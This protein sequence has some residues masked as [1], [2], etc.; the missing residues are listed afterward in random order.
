MFPYFQ[1][2]LISLYTNTVLNLN[3]IAGPVLY[4][5]RLKLCSDKVQRI[6]RYM[7]SDL[8]VGKIS[9]QVVLLLRVGGAMKNEASPRAS[10]AFRLSSEY[11][12]PPLEMRSCCH[13]FYLGLIS[14]LNARSVSMSW[15]KLYQL[16]FG[17]KSSSPC[18]VDMTMLE[19][20]QISHA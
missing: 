18:Q 2:A 11:S 20:F 15:S 3:L 1:A 13:I 7:H 10:N 9:Q 17:K 5:L 16:W 14:I 8:I 19:Y 4:P 12:I 6:L